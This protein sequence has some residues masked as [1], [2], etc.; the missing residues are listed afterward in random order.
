MNF[1]SIVNVNVY[2]WLP[3][4]VCGLCIN[5]GGCCGGHNPQNIA[6]LADFPNLHI[7]SIDQHYHEIADLQIQSNM[8]KWFLCWIWYLWKASKCTISFIWQECTD[9]KV[10]ANLNTLSSLSSMKLTPN[11]EPFHKQSAKCHFCCLLKY[12]PSFL[13]SLQ[14]FS[15]SYSPPDPYTHPPSIHCIQITEV[16]LMPNFE[17]F[18][19]QSATCLSSRHSIS[20]AT[21]S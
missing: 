20:V 14:F 8:K 19:K 3:A 4:G 18:H 15:N 5:Q 11:F 9:G 12:F 2:D 17:P 7:Q 21:V 16:V 10:K 1:T 6:T 13:V